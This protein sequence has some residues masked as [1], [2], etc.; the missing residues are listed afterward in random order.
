[1]PVTGDFSQLA[2]IQRKVDLIQKE[3]AKRVAKQVGLEAK[4]L[5]A[6]GFAR[7]VSPSGQ[8]WAPLKVRS[9][10]PLRDSGRLASSITLEPTGLGFRLTSNV[11]YADVHQYGATITVK[12]ARSLYS[13]SLRTFFGK[14]VTIPARPFLPEGDLPGPWNERLTEAAEEALEILFG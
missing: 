8:A 7:G 5:V 12:K 14:T 1:M 2:A 3:G 4:A 13:P 10:Q 6:E 9:G 11:A